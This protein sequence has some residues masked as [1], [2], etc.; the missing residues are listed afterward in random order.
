L[1]LDASTTIAW[2]L[3]ESDRLAARPWERMR[4]S[5]EDVFDRMEA[6]LDARGTRRLFSNEEAERCAVLIRELTGI[7]RAVPVA[8]DDPWLPHPPAFLAKEGRQ[9]RRAFTH[10][11]YPAG[12]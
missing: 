4:R 6:M 2:A 10:I 7:S 8:G 1:V 11:L 9:R 3:N 12:K 5:F